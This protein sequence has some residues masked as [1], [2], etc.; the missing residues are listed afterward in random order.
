MIENRQQLLVTG[1]ILH[2]SRWTET[3]GVRT[4]GAQRDVGTITVVNPNS[5]ATSIQLFDARGGTRREIARRIT[6]YSE[7]YEFTASNMSLDNLAAIFG[8]QAVTSYTQSGTAVVDQAGYTAFPNSVIH[9]KDASGNYLYNIASI[10]AVKVGV[11]TLVA[12]TDYTVDPNWLKM[13]YFRINA[14]AGVVAAGTAITVSYTPTAITNELRVFNP[15]TAGVPNVEAWIYWT[16][17]D[18]GTIMLRD[19]VDATLQPAALEFK[20][21]DFSSMRFTI[22][23]KSTPT[24]AGRPAGRFLQPVGGLAPTSY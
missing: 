8:A 20:D 21:A 1:S 17:D 6:E 16:S 9:L 14:P 22:T 15:H 10:Q 24:V 3:D 7:T 23:I 2:L 18:Y 5:A 11:T 4:Y 13:G 19:H 12:G